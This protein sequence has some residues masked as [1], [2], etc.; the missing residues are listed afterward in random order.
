MK[1]QMVT[2]PKVLILIV[3]IALILCAS[4]ACVA[5]LQ[6]WN[7]IKRT[8]SLLLLSTP[9]RQCVENI[10]NINDLVYVE[11]LEGDDIGIG[12]LVDQDYYVAIFH[13]AQDAVCD[14]E[15]Q[16][17]AWD[18]Y[19]EYQAVYC[20]EGDYKF[21]P[22]KIERV[23]LTGSPPEEI[24][25]WFDVYGMGNRTG[26]KHR[27]YVEQPGGSFEAVLTLRLCVSL[28]SVEIDDESHEIVATDD[29]VCDMFHGRK[30]HIRYSLH[31]GMPQRLEDWYDE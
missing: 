12:Y 13:V 20:E 1:H 15:F 2:V 19:D 27:F 29:V 7:G 8:R 10:T 25:A 18:C 3:L 17:K 22:Q 9:Q 6:L 24:Y 30:E 4:F 31:D 23:E 16:E 21:K 26:A 5:G 14:I 28:S 11:K